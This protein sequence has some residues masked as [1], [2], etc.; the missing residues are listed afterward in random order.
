MGVNTKVQL[1][2]IIDSLSDDQYENM[3]ENDEFEEF[4]KKMGHDCPDDS[5]MFVNMMDEMNN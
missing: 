2:D 1:L 3:R 4:F 5:E